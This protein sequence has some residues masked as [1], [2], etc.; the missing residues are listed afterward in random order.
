VKFEHHLFDLTTLLGVAAIVA[1]VGLVATAVSTWR[2]GKIDVGLATRLCAPSSRDRA[3]AVGRR[4]FR[5][6]R[7]RIPRY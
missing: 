3:G 6:L 1:V 7:I 2:V 5:T 4:R